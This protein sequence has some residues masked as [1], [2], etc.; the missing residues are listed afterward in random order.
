MTTGR[1]VQSAL[2]IG[3]GTVRVVIAERVEDDKIRLLGAGVAASKGLS[4][5]MPLAVKPMVLAVEEAIAA[6]EERAGI[7]ID[8]IHLGVSGAELCSSNHEAHLL[9]TRNPLDTRSSLIQEQHKR[10]VNDL[11]EHSQSVQ[12]DRT[13]LHRLTQEYLVD[14]AEGVVNPVGLH[15]MRLDCRTHF[16]S[17]PQNTVESLKACVQK[18]SVAVGS[19]SLTSLAASE[20]ALSPDEREL[21]VLLMDFG[22]GSTDLMLHA[23]GK[24]RHAASVPVG[25]AAITSDI[26][27]A[28]RTPGSEAERIKCQHGSCDGRLI[29]RDERFSIQFAGGEGGE[30]ASRSQLC[31]VI[32][33]R[34]EEILELVERELEASNMRWMLGGGIVITG[35]GACLEGL[36]DL[37]RER[38]GLPVRLGVPRGVVDMDSGPAVLEWTP[39]IGLARM[40]LQQA[41]VRK[42]SQ[43]SRTLMGWVNR[44]RKQVAL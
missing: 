3:H 44:L 20:A 19:V 18:S 40:A 28:F 43:A 13:V 17:V 24:V 14:G 41:P 21:G 2:D 39:V 26:S 25:A 5:G 16:L 4:R 11:A 38:Y 8:E 1:A 42:G 9:V 22:A 34:M 33:P 6:A 12:I 32:Q 36:V 30:Q 7:E 29:R 27:R 37:V 31:Q 23:D 35:G 10:Q 15:G